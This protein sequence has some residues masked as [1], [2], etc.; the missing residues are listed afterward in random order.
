VAPA[1]LGEEQ[2]K[3][4]AGIL[5]CQRGE[6]RETLKALERRLQA[7]LPLAAVECRRDV[8]EVAAAYVQAEATVVGV[9]LELGMVP[10]VECIRPEIQV[11]ALGKGKGFEERQVKVVPSETAAGIT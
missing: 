6:V 11:E 5:R 10:G 7:E 8:A 4:P 9:T 1:A 3:N 2:K